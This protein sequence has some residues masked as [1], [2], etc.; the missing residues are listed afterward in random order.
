M[1]SRGAPVCSCICVGACA[2][3]HMYNISLLTSERNICIH[4]AARERV[5]SSIHERSEREIRAPVSSNSLQM[6]LMRILP[7]TT[8]A[9]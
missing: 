9:L 5:R 1:P 3:L 6:D 4:P 7:A 8:R 2:Y